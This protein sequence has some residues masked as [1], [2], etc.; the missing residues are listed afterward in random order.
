MGY[1]LTVCS[2][3]LRAASQEPSEA[4]TPAALETTARPTPGPEL[5]AGEA[6]VPSEDPSAV[7]PQAQSAALILAPSPQLSATY[8]GGLRHLSLSP[9]EDFAVI[10]T[11]LGFEG[12]SEA[13]ARA[14]EP[15]IQRG[16]A[17][18]IRVAEDIVAISGITFQFV[19]MIS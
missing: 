10:Q 19:G 16:I 8:R 5:S 15:A 11:A 4:P 13:A 7:P 14:I 18:T 12:V 1:R 17:T 2:L 6:P 3:L 9:R